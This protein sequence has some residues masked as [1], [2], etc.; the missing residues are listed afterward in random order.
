MGAVES[1]GKATPECRCVR[2][3]TPVVGCVQ[4]SAL[5]G[6][7]FLRYST[8]GIMCPLPLSCRVPLPCLDPSL[9]SF[10]TTIVLP[11]N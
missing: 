3:H 5:L 9:M 11:L 2:S 8:P 4:S 6:S 1:G 7:Y 10:R